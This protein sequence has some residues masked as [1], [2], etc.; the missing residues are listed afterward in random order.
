MMENIFL[1]PDSGE[2]KRRL[3]RR[4]KEAESQAK[5][6]SGCHLTGLLNV[7]VWLPAQLHHAPYNPLCFATE[8]GKYPLEKASLCTQRIR[9]SMTKVRAPGGSPCV[10]KMFSQEESSHRL[11]QMGLLFLSCRQMSSLLTFYPKPTLT[12]CLGIML[13]ISFLPQI[14]VLHKPCY[15]QNHQGLNRTPDRSIIS[16]V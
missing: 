10:D 8:T 7:Q 14:W 11:S 12:A 5:R 2:H 13:D 16:N 1:V 6:N 15:L 3:G 4:N 9:E